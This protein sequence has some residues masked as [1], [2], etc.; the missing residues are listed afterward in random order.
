MR[1]GQF[2]VRG[3]RQD[4]SRTGLLTLPDFESAYID[5]RIEF[6]PVAPSVPTSSFPTGSASG[7]VELI[8][9]TPRDDG[10]ISIGIADPTYRMSKLAAANNSPTPVAPD[11]PLVDAVTLMLSND[12]SQLP[13]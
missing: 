4:L 10:P 12:F 1:R 8:V 5:A 3:L 2:I 6:A 9:G 7:A 11:R 13:V